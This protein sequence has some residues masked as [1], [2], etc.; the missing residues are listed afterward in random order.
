MILR[1]VVLDPMLLSLAGI[2]V[3]GPTDLSM[4]QEKRSSAKTSTASKGLQRAPRPLILKLEAGAQE[5]SAI[6]ESA[7]SELDRELRG[8]LRQQNRKGMDVIELTIS[9]TGPA[10]VLDLA[11]V[12]RNFVPESTGPWDKQDVLSFLA[13]GDGPVYLNLSLL[14]SLLQALTSYRRQVLVRLG[15]ASLNIETWSVTLE[16]SSTEICRYRGHFEREQPIIHPTILIQTRK[17]DAPLEIKPEG[18]GVTDALA[19]GTFP[20]PP[21]RILGQFS[22]TK[23]V[24]EFFGKE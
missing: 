12:T 9:R 11:M 22:S 24:M 3:V 13:G 2:L 10:Q 1:L 6:F 7:R 5:Y 21:L 19:R 20:L 4:A 8:I 18:E 23:L 15:G 14:Q 17:M 16:K